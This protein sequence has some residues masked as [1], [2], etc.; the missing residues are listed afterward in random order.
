MNRHSTGFTLIELI[1]SIA[2][3]A[4]MTALVIAR[5]GTF[6]Q[7]TLV[8]NVAYD[9]ALTLKTAQTY[10]LSVKSSDPAA[11][12]FTAAYGIHFDM[13]KPTNFIFFAD[14]NSPS[15]HKYDSS[16]D[17]AITTYSLN[18]N[19]KISNICLGIDPAT[20]SLSGYT[21]SATDVFDITYKRPNPDALFYCTG[22]CSASNPMP[23]PIVFITI[24]SSDG[25]NNQIVY[26]RSNGQISVGN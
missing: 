24:T 16:P 3:F 13:H 25:S 26:V 5:Y 21:L 17:E 23:Q 8:T 14:S 18:S 2:I 22:S 19:S 12:N 15:N 10:G 7:N 6:N 4:A 9:M 20:C 11:S 1:I